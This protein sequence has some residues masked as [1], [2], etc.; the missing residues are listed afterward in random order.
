MKEAL[1]VPVDQGTRPV[2]LTETP[3]MISMNVRSSERAP[4]TVKIP[5]EAMNVSVQMASDLWVIN[6]GSSVQLMVILHCY[7][8]QIMCGFEGTISHQNSTLTIS[9]TRSTSKLW[10]MTGTLK[11]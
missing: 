7:C 4:K 5:K 11:E 8:C 10:I 2:R 1:S 3:V 9:I 6:K